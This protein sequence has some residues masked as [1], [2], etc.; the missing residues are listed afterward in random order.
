M[1]EDR[2]WKSRKRGKGNE[3]KGEEGKKRRG[4]RA[5]VLVLGGLCEGRPDTAGSSELQ[6][7]NSQDVAS[8]VTYFKKGKTSTQT[9]EERKKEAVNQ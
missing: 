3:R 1:R 9:E 5:E 4:A 6:A 8:L 2:R 7:G